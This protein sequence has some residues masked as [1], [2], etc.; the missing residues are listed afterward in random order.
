MLSEDDSS[1]AGN[2]KGCDESEFT[3]TSSSNNTST[4]RSSG[5]QSGDNDDGGYYDSVVDSLHNLEVIAAAQADTNNNNN[6]E[7]DI[8]NQAFAA[9]ESDFDIL[10]DM[11]TQQLEAAEMSLFQT[12]GN[13]SKS[14]QKRWKL[15]GVDPTYS[16]EGRHALFVN[17]TN[18]LA[19][20]ALHGSVSGTAEIVDHNGAVLTTTY[21]DLS[22]MV[23]TYA[24]IFMYVNVCV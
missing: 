14:V 15:V 2:L 17:L 9:M 7:D 16:Y 8:D 5:D 3:K 10:Q 4:K 18:N 1:A 23:Q 20:I 6:D 19:K 13:P 12:E 21:P 11:I 24:Y 22:H